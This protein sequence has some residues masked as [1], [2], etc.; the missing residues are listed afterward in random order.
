MEQIIQSKPIQYNK[1]IVLK[2]TDQGLPNGHWTYIALIDRNIS[3]AHWWTVDY[4]QAFK[5]ISKKAADTKAKS[6]KYGPCIV[7]NASEFD[8]YVGR[9]FYKVKLKGYKLKHELSLKEHQFDMDGNDTSYDEQQAIQDM[10]EEK[11][12]YDWKEH[13]NELV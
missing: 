7:I 9:E 13:I 4:E 1:F 3:K 2:K 6:L 12:G 10:L 5:F 11:Y 8:K